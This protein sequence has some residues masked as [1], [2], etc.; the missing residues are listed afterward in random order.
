MVNLSDLPLILVLKNFTLYLP[1]INLFSSG[2]N[3]NKVSAL[4]NKESFSKSLIAY[5]FFVTI[6]ESN[7]LK[8]S[9]KSP[10]MIV[11]FIVSVIVTFFVPDAYFFK[12][13]NIKLSPS[14]VLLLYS[15]FALVL[16]KPFLLLVL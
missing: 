11:L 7:S 5:A 9:A 15:I 2:P 1:L 6:A 3:A 8:T 16:K 12:S 10:L 13:S 14:I 4:I